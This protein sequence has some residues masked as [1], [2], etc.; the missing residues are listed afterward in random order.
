MHDNQ[1]IRGKTIPK[2]LSVETIRYIMVS[3]DPCSR[4][5][6][7]AKSLVVYAVG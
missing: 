7:V 2:T 4:L 5:N 6:L 1:I 3:L